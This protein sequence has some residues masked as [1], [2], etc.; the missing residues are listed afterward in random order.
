MTWFAFQ[1]LNGGKAVNLAGS[2]EKQAVAEGFHGYGTEAQAEASPNSVNFLTR[3]FADA[4]IADYA[5]AR[6]E[7]A[8]PGGKNANIL[9]PATA[10]KA[11]AQG[12]TTAAKDAAGATANAT[13]LTAIG[14]FFSGLTSVNLWIRVA[15]VTVGGLILIVG[16]VK[17]TG[18]DGQAP[19]VVRKAVRAAPLL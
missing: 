16:L 12:V 5:A 8:Q 2:Q 3:Y 10:A 18:L 17:L 4:W 9:N 13:G 7:Q 15:K 11:G 6:A 1:G 14:G 19:A